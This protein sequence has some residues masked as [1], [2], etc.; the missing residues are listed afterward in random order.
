LSDRNLSKI[1]IIA[2]REFSHTALTKAFLFGAVILP[3]GMMGLLLVLPLLFASQLKPLDG[4]IAVVD[5]TGRFVQ[6][7][8]TLVV[9]RRDRDRSGD[10]E[11]IIRK[12]GIDDRGGMLSG[13]IAAAAE[14]ASFDD[15]TATDFRPGGDDVILRLKEEA[16]DG[17]WIAVAVIPEALFDAKNPDEDLDDAMIDLF[18]PKETSPRH[19]DTISDLIRSATVRA[20]FAAAGEDFEYIQT[21]LDRP[22]VD[23]RRLGIEAGS[24][25]SDSKL[26]MLVPFGFMMLLWIATFTA[27]NFLL[28]STIEEKSNKVI[29][30]VLSAV[31]PLQLLWGKILGL[32][33]VSLVILITYGGLAI[34]GIA[35]LALTDLLS[36]SVLLWAVV[37][38][39][40]AY[41][42]VAALMAAIGSAVNELSEA[43]T[44]MAPVMV[45]LITP[46]LLWMPIGENPNGTLAVVTS[47]LPPILPF[48]M[49]M[50][51]GAA[52][53]PVPIW[54]LLLSTAIGIV[55]VVGL[56]WAASRIFRV[57]ILMQGKP[58]SPLE[59]LRWIRQ[60]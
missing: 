23:I 41:F 48:A 37:F 10:A 57:G 6:A 36:I 30:V 19:G 55:S 7:F 53:D 11:E 25:S 49:V 9:E 47:M 3:I 27:G 34:A 51:I 12:L 1:G 13:G 18:L 26:R 43:Q 16:R 39:L 21:M 59:L 5:S 44:F 52:T 40:I 29:E 32:A 24:E 35:A 56:V 22:S 42:T 20:R 14:E 4:D 58:P 8:N 45:I 54:Q 50:R 33:L 31:G 60:S 28:T 46:M 15:V 2:W 17:Q 38:F